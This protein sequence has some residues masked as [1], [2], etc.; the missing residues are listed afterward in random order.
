LNIEKPPAGEHPHR[1][2]TQAKA[3]GFAGG[4]FTE[5]PASVQ[6]YFSID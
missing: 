5:N 1:V 3:T 2:G 6:F 4:L